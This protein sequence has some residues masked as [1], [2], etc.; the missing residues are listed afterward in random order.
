MGPLKL[1]EY[2][3]KKVKEFSYFPFCLKKT[4]SSTGTVYAFHSVNG[5]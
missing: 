3:G 5:L 1:E 2:L 4:G